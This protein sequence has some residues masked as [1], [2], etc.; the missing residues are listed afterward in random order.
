M[1]DC[2]KK[3]NRVVRPNDEF[4]GLGDMWLG[5]DHDE[6][7]KFWNKL[8]GQKTIIRGNHDPKWIKKYA[9]VVDYHE[10]KIDHE[11]FVLM[12]YPLMSW[13]KSAKGSYMLHGHV[14]GFLQ[15][16]NEGTRR[17]DVGYDATGVW[18]ISLAEVKERLKDVKRFID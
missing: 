15:S 2:L 4:Y 13:R 10:L 12:H 14:H 6:F 11:L 16:H 17:L 18:A 9:E 8:N 3:F 7:R 5:K 1:D